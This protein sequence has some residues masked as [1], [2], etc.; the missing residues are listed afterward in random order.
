MRGGL[1]TYSRMVSVSTGPLRVKRP[2]ALA[3]GGGTMA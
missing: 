1:E 3:L 2:E